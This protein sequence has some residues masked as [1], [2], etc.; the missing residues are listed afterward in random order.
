MALGV[1]AGAAPAR[2]QAEGARV[3]G[4]GMDPPAVVGAHSELRVT[5][6]AP[7]AAVSGLVA[8]FGPGNTFGSS[9]CQMTDIPGLRPRGPFAPGAPVSLA[10]PN[11][12]TRRG[13]SEVLVRLSSGGCRAPVGA[14]VRVV[15]VHPRRPDE[16]PVAPTLIGAP[17]PGAPAP[18]LP[19]LDDLP[20]LSVP[21]LLSRRTRCP[22][23]GVHPSR[24]IHAVR[25]ARAALLCLLNAQRRAHHLPRLRSSP[26]LLKAATAHSRAMVHRRFFSHDQPGGLDPLRRVQLAGY[27]R[28]AHHLLVGENIGY[29]VGRSSTPRWMVRAWMHSSPHRATILDRRFRDVG[30]GIAR[31]APGRPHARG[32]TYTTDFGLRRR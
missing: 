23:S 26:R 14:P 17:A 1:A 12:F 19:G 18:P 21:A 7:G 9:A 20:P 32:A 11:R 4:V 3:L 2:A 31:G 27:P 22:G 16:R 5:A 15:R 10:A 6:A 28:G 25:V 8:R 24:S 29:G 13:T 30:L